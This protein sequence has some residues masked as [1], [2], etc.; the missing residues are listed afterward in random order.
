M[1]GAYESMA[2]V[3]DKFSGICYPYA[4]HFPFLSFC[5]SK[6]IPGLCYIPLPTHLLIDLCQHLLDVAVTAKTPSILS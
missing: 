2:N 4:G 6:H 5:V 1:P 3:G